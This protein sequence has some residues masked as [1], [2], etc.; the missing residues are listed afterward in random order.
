MELSTERKGSCSRF[1]QTY[2]KAPVIPEA[3]SDD[4]DKEG[5]DTD[6]A[7]QGSEKNSKDNEDN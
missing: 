3:M 2:P 4:E 5:K 7:E 6:G 1:P